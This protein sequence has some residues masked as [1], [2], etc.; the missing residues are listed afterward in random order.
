MEPIVPS[1]LMQE[2][3][4]LPYL[5][6]CHEHAPRAPITGAMGI[7]HPRTGERVLTLHVAELGLIPGIMED[8]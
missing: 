6:S 5:T 1:V 2:H 4:T 8:P 3:S 7:V